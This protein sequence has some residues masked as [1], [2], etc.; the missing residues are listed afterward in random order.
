[1]SYVTHLLLGSML[2]TAGVARPH[3][4]AVHDIRRFDFRNFVYDAGGDEVRIRGGRGKYRGR[5]EEVFA[6]SVERVSVTYGDLN[7]DGGDEAA[8]TI[9]YT[10]GGTGAFST[11]FVFTLRR[12]RLSLLA[13]FEGGDR[14]DG[15]IREVRIGNGLL[16]V[17]RNEPERMNNVPVGLCCPLYMLTTTYRWDGERLL[18][19][20][21]AEK[22]EL[23]EN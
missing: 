22:V 11:G 17:Q 5:G 18:Q 14:A 2:L 8:V 12:G 7:G 6:Y 3:P 1:M 19:V 4:G 23:D 9:F 15:G 16:R 21:A 13:P 10:G 20:G